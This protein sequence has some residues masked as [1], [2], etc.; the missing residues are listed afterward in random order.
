[1]IEV[2]DRFLT[3]EEYDYVLRYCGTSGYYYGETDRP[4]V[5]PTGMVH[6]IDE[7]E[8]IYELFASRTQELVPELRLYRMYVNCFSPAE[9]PYFHTDGDYGDVTFLFYVNHRWDLDDG[10]ETQFFENGE[11][12]GIVPLPNRMVYF[13]ANIEHRAT[14]LRHR[15]RFTIAI[16]YTA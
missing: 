16:K 13:D 12:R 7:K 4:D 15:H 1:M 10:G 2:L 9:N 8:T 3:D 5:M 11:I 14:S 6:E